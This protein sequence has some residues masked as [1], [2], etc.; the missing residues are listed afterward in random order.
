MGSG[1]KHSD[2]GTSG[3]GYQQDVSSFHHHHTHI[4]S[5]SYHNSLPLLTDADF[6]LTPLDSVRVKLFFMPRSVYELSSLDIV[7]WHQFIHSGAQ[8]IWRS[9]REVNALI[10]SN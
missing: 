8:R 2:R 1:R 9:A 7:P 4:Y 10:I 3:H 5:F 6:F